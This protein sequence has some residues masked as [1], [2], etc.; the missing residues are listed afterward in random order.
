MRLP[1]HALSLVVVL[2]LA[3]AVPAVSAQDY[4][5]SF[6]QSQQ[7]AN[8]REIQQEGREVSRER[9]SSNERAR[10]AAEHRRACMQRYR[11]YDPRTDTYVARPGV[12]VRCRL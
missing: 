12:R 10:S 6:L 9:P 7:D 1:V 3:V 4:L 2:P 5:G 11:T 8:I